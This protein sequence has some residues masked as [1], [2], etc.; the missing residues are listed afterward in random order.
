[1]AWL[2]ILI[3]LAGIATGIVAILCEHREKMAMIA[4]GLMPQEKRSQGSSQPEDTLRKG[5]VTASLGVAFL[6][7]QV[8]GN[9]NSWFLVPAFILI[10]TGGALVA[11]VFL[12]RHI[13]Q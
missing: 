7:A 12:R 9:L 3:P 1:M 6:L 2:W 4:K 11:T 13:P 10:C 8:L 5:I